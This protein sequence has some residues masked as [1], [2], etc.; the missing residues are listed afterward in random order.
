LL[1]QRPQPFDH[2]DW[3]FE[4]GGLKAALEP[5]ALATLD[6]RAR[7]LLERIPDQARQ[8]DVALV[9]LRVL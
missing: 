1:A 8:D 2:P 5:P 3:I 6:G 9:I 4:K 7:S